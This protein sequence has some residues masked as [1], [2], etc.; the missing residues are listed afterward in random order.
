[1]AKIILTCKAILL[2]GAVSI[3]VTNVSAKCFNV[4]DNTHPCR[5]KRGDA[6][7]TENTTLSYAYN[8]NCLKNHSSPF[9]NNQEQAN[10]LQEPVTEKS[11]GE[12]PNTS[13][14]TIPKNES[15][16]KPVPSATRG[17][18][19]LQS[20]QASSVSI[21]TPAATDSDE[22]QSNKNA[23]ADWRTEFMSPEKIRELDKYLEGPAA[24]RNDPRFKVFLS[25]YGLSSNEVP[26]S[27]WS[28]LLEIYRNRDARNNEYKERLADLGNQYL[29]TERLR[30]YHVKLY[31]ELDAIWNSGTVEQAE[32]VLARIAG[33]IGSP[34]KDWY[35][36]SG[37]SRTCFK[38]G[39]PAERIAEL[40]AGADN[41]E[42]KD[43]SNGGVEVGYYDNDGNFHFRTYF[44]SKEEC[45]ANLPANRPIPDK[46][47]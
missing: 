19:S 44:P 32:D 27:G 22:V 46:Y 25:K 11:K 47:K 31:N 21:T 24:A 23:N 30:K 34:G 37:D 40:Q 29:A 42:T 3:T 8:N 36:I 26:D 28:T 33:T 5:Y 14:N 43:L 10:R 45:I 38:K 35:V 17:Q 2:L 16:L 18:P 9:S 6:W 15:F 13:S 12:Q 4:D 41:M 7:C 39:T 1:M 20:Q